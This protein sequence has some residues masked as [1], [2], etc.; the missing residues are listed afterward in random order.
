MINLGIHHDV[1]NTRDLM[2]HFHQIR[3]TIYKD[4]IAI[5]VL[6]SSTNCHFT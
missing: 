1:F 3:V 5:D 4:L 2:L 6:G